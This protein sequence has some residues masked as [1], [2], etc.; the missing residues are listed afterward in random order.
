V[1]E[2][3]GQGLPPGRIPLC[4]SPSSPDKQRN[5]FD[6]KQ[7]S[8]T[9]KLSLFNSSFPIEEFQQVRSLPS[10]CYLDN[11]I[12]EAESLGIFG[13]WVGAGCISDVANPLDYFTQEITGEP[14]VVLKDKNGTLK[15]FLNSCRHNG[16]MLLTEPKGKLDDKLPCDY[17][18]WGYKIAENTGDLCRA[19]KLGKVDWFCPKEYSLHPFEAATWGP[20]IFVRMEPGTDSLSTM[21]EPIKQWTADKDLS[22]FK[23]EYRWEDEVECNWKTYVENFLDG[24]YHVKSIHRKLAQSLNLDKYCTEVS[25][26]CNL[27]HTPMKNNANDPRQG[28]GAKYLWLS[29][30]TMVNIYEDA[31]DTNIVLPLGPNKC[32]IIFDFFFTDGKKKSDKNKYIT[33]AKQVQLED[34][35]VCERV[36]H[37]LKSRYYEPGPYAKPEIGK[38]HFRKILAETFS[39][40]LGK[41]IYKSV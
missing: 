28:S 14:L 39:R 13:G 2:P 37:G 33:G 8:L 7:M 27:Q 23:W 31:M 34:K 10:I 20:L 15:A 11:E 36:M 17:H 5:I 3:V 25:G 1:I 4:T 9:E 26:H 19:P 29:P 38:F 24:G 32:K 16:T 18:D 30:N 40:E 22:K 35:R 6:N 41:F 12:Y 21:L